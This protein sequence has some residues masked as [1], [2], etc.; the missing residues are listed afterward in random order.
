[1]TALAN[2]I[3]LAYR[4]DAAFPS[5]S[6][7]FYPGCPDE[8]YLD[9]RELGD[10]PEATRERHRWVY[11]AIWHDAICLL[12]AAHGKEDDMGLGLALGEGT[13]PLPSWLRLCLCP[14]CPLYSLWL[15]R[16]LC[17][18]LPLPL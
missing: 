3:T 11:G 10:G 18:V 17:P 4:L 13:L 5:W 14:V 16:C 7:T 2:L 15:R 1:M 8:E 9:D 6:K 12:V